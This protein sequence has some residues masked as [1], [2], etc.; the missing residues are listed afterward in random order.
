[1]IAPIDPARRRILI[2]AFDMPSMKKIMSR[3]T[4]ITPGVCKCGGPGALSLTRRD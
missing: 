4:S 2:A 3:K 1:M